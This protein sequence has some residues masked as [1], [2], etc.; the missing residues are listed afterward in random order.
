MQRIAGL[1]PAGARPRG[2]LGDPREMLAVLGLLLLS[3]AP[4]LWLLLAHPAVPI[5]DFKT[6]VLFAE[7]FARGGPF[8]PGWYWDLLS[9]GTSS[10]IAPFMAAWPGH[11]AAVARWLTFLVMALLPLVPVVALRGAVPAKARLLMGALI[12]L[13]PAQFVFSNV[14]SQDNWIQLPVIVLACLA[15]RNERLRGRGVPA[16]AALLLCLSMYIRQEMLLVCLPL[17]VLAAWPWNGSRKT[18]VRASVVF[19]VVATLCSL[20]VAVQREGAT[21]R[22]ALTTKHG[23]AALLGSYVPGAGFGWVPYDDYVARVAPGIAGDAK[24]VRSHAAGLAI[25]EILSRPGFHLVRRTGATLNAATGAD[26]SLAYWSLYAAD[27]PTNQAS[28]GRALANRLQ[29]WIVAGFV[30]VH[31]LF[32]GAML[33]ALRRRDLAMLAL[34]AAIAIKLALHLVIATQARFFLVAGSLEALA[35]GLAFVHIASSRRLLVAF[36][37][38]ALVAAAGLSYCVSRLPGWEQAALQADARWLDSVTPR[39]SRISLGTADASVDCELVHG[40]MLELSGA[41][42]AFQVERAD[43]APGDSAE[44]RCDVTARA[45]PGGLRLEV[46]DGYAAGGFPDRMFQQVWIDGELVYNHDISARAWSGWWPYELDL[47]RGKPVRVVVA[48]KALHPDPGPGWGN[49][50]ATG[51]RFGE[52]EKP[53]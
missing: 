1:D 32:A 51:V 13:Q 50:A 49:A 26:G 12:A 39:P 7:S 43:P 36:A 28:P 3:V 30:L 17:A 15:I 2:R 25:R 14:V 19:L 31:A 24:A 20:L 6:I 37:A 10:L 35:I 4:K 40:K 47:S 18:L 5:S 16:L 41:S 29:P 33:P 34:A 38:A 9:P 21:G 23:G 42:L 44:L 8:A 48:V 45:A 27:P 53:R 22:F 46:Q 52:L 11:D